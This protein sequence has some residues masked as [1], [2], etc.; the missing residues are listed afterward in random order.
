MQLL[1]PL[2]LLPLRTP[3]LLL[4]AIPGVL[5]T[6]LTTG[7]GPA[8]SIH[9][10]YTAYSHVTFGFQLANIAATYYCGITRS[11]PEFLFFMAVFLLVS[12]LIAGWLTRANLQYADDGA[13][14]A[15]E[16]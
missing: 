14:D 15:S 13:G 7:Y 1:V 8:L 10:H 2:A 12:G 9:F 5:F 16:A 3:W 4:L 6:L 11:Y